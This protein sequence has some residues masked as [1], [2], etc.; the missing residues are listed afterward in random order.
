[1][2]LD[3]GPRVSA[4]LPPSDRRTLVRAPAPRRRTGFSPTRAVMFLLI[5]PVNALEI[6]TMALSH[7][8][9]EL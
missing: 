6:L 2:L 8:P 9:S 1:M 7:S 5:N 3:G 4:D